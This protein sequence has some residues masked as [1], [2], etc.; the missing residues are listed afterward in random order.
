MNN[1]RRDYLV[2]INGVESSLDVLDD[3]RVRPL[4]TGAALVLF[5]WTGAAYALVF[6][7]VLA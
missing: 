1:P 2:Y 3:P 6:E 4:L 5:R 7:T